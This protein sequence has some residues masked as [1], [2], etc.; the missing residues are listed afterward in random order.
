MV[1]AEEV[2]K[3]IEADNVKWMALQFTDLVREL[4]TTFSIS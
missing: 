2:L 4:E 1:K 3:S